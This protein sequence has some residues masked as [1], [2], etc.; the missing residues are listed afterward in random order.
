MNFPVVDEIY[1]T[2]MAIA[3]LVEFN[4][5]LIDET[6]RAQYLGDKLF[7]VNAKSFC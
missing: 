5:A 2:S 6:M 1:L 7:V 3:S 4:C